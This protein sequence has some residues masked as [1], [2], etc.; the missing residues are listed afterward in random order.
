MQVRVRALITKMRTYWVWWRLGVL[1]LAT[2]ALGLAS[3]VESTALAVALVCVASCGAALL[4]GLLGARVERH[5][6]ELS[7]LAH[8]EL[9]PDGHGSSVAVPARPPL[10]PDGTERA[11]GTEP[12]DCT[13]V[14][15][16][17]EAAHEPEALRAF[18]DTCVE[19]M[20]G[21]EWLVALPHAS[22]EAG[23]ALVG[24]VADVMQRCPRLALYPVEPGGDSWLEA[25][26]TYAAG[27]YILAIDTPRLDQ[28]DCASLA[29]LL[30]ATPSP[31]EPW[32][33]RRRDPQG[34]MLLR[35]SALLETG[36]RSAGPASSHTLDERLVAAGYLCDTLPEP[37]Q[38]TGWDIAGSAGLSSVE[39]RRLVRRPIET[40]L[41][42][43]AAT[44]H[45][46]LA[47]MAAY[48]CAE[49][50]PLAAALARRGHRPAFIVGEGWFT[51]VR[52]ALAAST[53]PIFE[54][55][56]AGAWLSSLEGLV[57]MND[58]DA[59]LAPLIDAADGYGVPTWPRSKVCR[60]SRTSTS[61]VDR[62]PYRRV[63][64]VAVPG[65]Q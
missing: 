60:T 27:R 58:W 50:V 48:H 16:G 10:V 13:V 28:I 4:L 15:D 35:R 43:H 2:A 12:V 57:V 18:L 6:L 19:A 24:I 14:I 37:A 63:D 39:P 25:G 44:R 30:A 11:V 20:P 42:D 22:I 29:R 49:L 33:G 62:R 64:H 41:D 38:L 45:V 65:P 7:D 54:V 23:D 52:P 21:V 34:L 61:D 51:Q 8:D 26:I 3:V 9:R 17:A 55:P 46:L 56:P 40:S 32:I 53:F 5:R 31:V 59:E 47:P 1:V 36:V